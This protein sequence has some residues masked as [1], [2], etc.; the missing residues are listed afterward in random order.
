M[1]WN[2]KTDKEEDQLWKDLCDRFFEALPSLSLYEESIRYNTI[3]RLVGMLPFLAKT[4]CPQRDS[5]SNL[6]LFIFTSF[7][8]SRDLFKLNPLD[9]EDILSRF[10]GIMCFTGGNS[11][12]IDRGL[13]LIALSVLYTYKNKYGDDVTGDYYKILSEDCCNHSCI[14]EELTLRVEQIPCRKMDKI[15]NLNSVQKVVWEH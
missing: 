10:Q 4:E 1:G 8:E 7:S 14:I 5:F 2:T 6:S 9:D 15:I 3:A 13:S 12:I 11:A